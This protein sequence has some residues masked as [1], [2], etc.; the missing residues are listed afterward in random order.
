[1]P[2]L[3]LPFQEMPDVALCQRL[4]GQNV[5]GELV[6]R[7]EIIPVER[8]GLDRQDVL[9]LWVVLRH[10][11]YLPENVLPHVRQAVAGA[12]QDPQAHVLRQVA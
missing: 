12:E 5:R 9:V 6:H 4:N 10:E 11:G 3:P 1:L 8:T 2:N 7:F